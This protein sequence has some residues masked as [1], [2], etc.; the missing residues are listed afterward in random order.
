[1]L[2]PLG[3]DEW[4]VVAQTGVFVGTYLGLAC[5]TVLG[6]SLLDTLSASMG[7]ER[8]RTT[9]IDTTMPL[10]LG[11]LF[12]LAG[13]G[14][15]VAAEAFRDIYPPPGTWGFW[16]LPGSAAFH[17]TWTGIAETLGGMGLLV[18]ALQNLVGGGDD[19]D[20]APLAVRFLQPASASGLFLLTLVVTPANIYMYTHG[21]VMGEAMAPL[22]ISFHAIRFSIQVL[23]LSLLWTLAKDSFFFAWG[24]E[25]D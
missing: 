7:L 15:F 10:V 13:V 3:I 25:L 2:S 5:G 19:D 11:T 14:H 6:S 1:M 9:V 22:D 23:L 20:D 16:Y 24:D 21:A 17:V 12:A 8:W 4:P 18:C